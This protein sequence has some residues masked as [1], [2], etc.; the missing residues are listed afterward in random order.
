MV[1]SNWPN[2]ISPGS[3]PTSSQ[4][5]RKI[6]PRRRAMCMCGLLVRGWAPAIPRRARVVI[7]TPD[8]WAQVRRAGA[9]PCAPTVGGN[10]STESGMTLLSG[11]EEQ[12]TRQHVCRY[13]C[14]RLHLV[15]FDPLQRHRM[16]EI[17]VRG[18]CASGLARLSCQSLFIQVEVSL[19]APQYLIVDFPLVAQADHRAPRG[20]ERLSL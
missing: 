5:G 16:R 11:T 6:A 1:C 10:G 4:F 7:S 15:R 20:L 17:G 3:L 12:S 18:S 9:Y 8:A 19:D 14:F 2:E 13:H